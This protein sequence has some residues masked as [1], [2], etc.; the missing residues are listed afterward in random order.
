MTEHRESH[1][2]QNSDFEEEGQTAVLESQPKPKRP[3]KY[4]V[5]MHNDDYTTMEFVVEVLKRHFHLS[6]EESYQVMMKVHQEGKGL[7]G[8]YS[9]DVAETK[10]T[11]VHDEAEQRG[12]PLRCTIEPVES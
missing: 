10:M 3:R 5:W 8:L 6:E 2:G 7:A 11:Q 9:F 1:A 12:F 4:G